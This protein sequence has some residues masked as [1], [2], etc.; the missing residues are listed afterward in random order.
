M[1]Y[2]IP[3]VLF[4]ITAFI[5]SYL[6]L[7][8]EQL[9]DDIPAILAEFNNPPGLDNNGSIYQLGMWSE[10]SDAPDAIGQWRLSQYRAA[11]QTA[12]NSTQEIT[13]EDYPE[14]LQIFELFDSQARPALLC[15]MT[16]LECLA[17]I[18]DHHQEIPALVERYQLF[19]ERYDTLMSYE[20]F[21]AYEQ[22]SFYLPQPDFGPSADIL[23]L[24]LLAIIY[25]MRNQQ[26]QQGIDEL[27]KL[28]QFHHKLLA[29]TPYMPVKIASTIEL[30]MV[31][32]SA[33]FLIAKSANKQDWQAFIDNLTTLTTTQLTFEKPFLHEFV[34]LVNTLEN[35]NI[36]EH[37]DELPKIVNFLPA[38]ILYK[39]NKTINT[40]YQWINSNISILKFTENNR[41]ELVAKTNPDDILSFDYRNAVGSTLVNSMAPK[42]LNLEKFLF[43]LEVKQQMLNY[44]YQLPSHHNDNDKVNKSY[45]SPFT[46]EPAYYRDNKF[47]L[48]VD[49][50]PANDICLFY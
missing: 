9:H 20:N 11:Q 29:Q 6:F 13:F 26:V 42:L 1:K 24:K 14:E 18:L 33:A 4:I 50:L 36:H 16:N 45:I 27:T 46:G 40:L 34:A 21:G 35:I 8:D 7:L 15:A 41:I 17:Y 48:A 37:D 43:Q 30:E 49:Q 32:D 38:K 25:Q 47:C 2:K 31:I 22:P 28:L 23:Q 44:L 39:K 10:I 3:L 19:I 12:T 5:F